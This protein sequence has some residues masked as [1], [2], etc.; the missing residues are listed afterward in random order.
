MN[1]QF[2]T[3]LYNALCACFGLSPSS[4]DASILIR[5]AYEEPENA[6]RPPRSMD[7]FIEKQE[8]N[9]S[10]QKKP[11]PADTRQ[12]AVICLLDYLLNR[13][14]F[15]CLSVAGPVIRYTSCGRISHCSVSP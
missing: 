10:Q 2:R 14:Y 8:K 5:E 15:L 13:G 12:I 11:C 4:S 6:P 3:A 7:L 1:Q 9:I